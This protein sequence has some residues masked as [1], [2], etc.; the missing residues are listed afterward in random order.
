MPLRSHKS[1]SNTLAKLAGGYVL[2]TG[3]LTGSVAAL[4]DPSNEPFLTSEVKSFT[5]APHSFTMLSNEDL[6]LRADQM[7]VDTLTPSQ[8]AMNYQWLSEHSDSEKHI[9]GEKAITKLIERHLKSYI[10][11]R[12]GGEW[13]KSKLMPDSDGSG[14]IKSVDYDVKLNANKLVIG[15]TYEF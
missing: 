14:F 10:D 3:L 5:G 9:H 11:E 12:A 15:I 8:R 7:R 4:A 6:A 13:I 1:T 2:L